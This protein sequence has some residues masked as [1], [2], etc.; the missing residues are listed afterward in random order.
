MNFGNTGA[1]AYRMRLMCL[2]GTEGQ[3]CAK[4]WYFIRCIT[5]LA[6]IL[7]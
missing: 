5:F 6:M 2:G 1:F 7:Y 4:T 3:N